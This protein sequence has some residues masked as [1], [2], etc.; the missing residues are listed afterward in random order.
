MEFYVF[1]KIDHRNLFGLVS[2]VDT[3]L[4]QHIANEIDASYSDF[5]FRSLQS[6][7]DCFERPFIAILLPCAWDNLIWHQWFSGDVVTQVIARARGGQRKA[8]DWFC[9]D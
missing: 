6:S 1:I 9:N 3:Q 5:L 8:A 2:L 4:I 7:L